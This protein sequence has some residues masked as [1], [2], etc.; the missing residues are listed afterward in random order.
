MSPDRETLRTCVAAAF[1]VAGTVALAGCARTSG[2]IGGEVPEAPLQITSTNPEP[3]STVDPF[4][5]P[6]R[7]QFQRGL[8]ERPLRGSP[9]E[10]VV[11]S[12]Q[13][14][15]LQV[16]SGGGGIEISME[17]GFLERT[18]YRITVLPRFRDRYDNV[19]TGAFDLIFSTGPE[20]EP[21]FLAGIV[22]D[23][24]S[25]AA[26]D[27]V[28][29]DLV[30]AEG[31]TPSSTLSDSTGV[32]ALPHLPAGRYA[33]VAY[34]DLNRNREPDFAEPQASSEVGMNRGD[35]LVV[36]ELM[37]LSPDTSAAVLETVAIQDSL[38]LRLTFDDYLNPSDLGPAEALLTREGANAPEVVE[39]LGLALWRVRQTDPDVPPPPAAVRPA[40]DLAIV[41]SRPLLPEVTYGVAVQGVVNLNGVPGGG[42]EGEVTGPPAAPAPPADPLPGDSVPGGVPPTDPLPGDSLPTGLPPADPLPG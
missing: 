3:F 7:I 18:V 29:V 9:V 35:T 2:Q 23:R 21:N 34:E 16:T 22:T 12:P 42:G 14:G 19:M 13:A 39:I 20:L 28:R 36:P 5:G 30:P 31:G 6:V 32:F 27:G 40:R 33:V 25:G 37:L 38:T 8:S 17:G 15:P 10:A 26:A 24:I 4:D 1:L 41:L 11:V